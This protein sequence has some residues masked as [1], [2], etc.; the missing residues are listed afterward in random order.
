[1][2]SVRVICPA[3]LFALHAIAHASPD[4]DPTKGR[5]VFTGAATAN[6]T[7]IEINPAALGL[8]DVDE[9]YVAATGTLNHLSI[10]PRTLDIDSGSL[11]DGP[12][13]SDSLASPGGMAAYVWHN[14]KDG[15]I[16]LGVALHSAPAERFIAGE[17]ALRYFTLGGS[18]R[19]IGGSIASSIRVSSRFYFGLSLSLHTS[20]FELK[21]AR[22]TA[23]E[24]ARDPARGIDSDCGNGTPCGVGNPAAAER[25]DVSARTSW[26]ALENLVATLGFIVKITPDITL[27]VGYHN[28]P[29]LALQNELT[30]TMSVER[31]PRDG[32]G[33]VDGGATVYLQQPAS[34]DA[35][36]KTHLPYDLDLHVG[37]R[38]SDLSRMQDYDVRGYGSF[39][40]GA[41]IP[42]WQPRARG[43]HDPF[44]FW[45]G[46]E[47][48]GHEAPLALGGRIG[49]ETSA[50]AND[51]TSPLSVAPL[52]FTADVGASYV[53]VPGKL[54]LQATYGVQY[55]PSVDVKDSAFDPRD[56]LACYDS[57]YDYSTTAC[58]GVR[59]GY[60]LSSAAGDYGRIEQAARIALH[61]EL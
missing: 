5:A 6:P 2:S 43:F 10:T 36:V 53:L 23:L 52:S 45:A 55:F 32:G 38:W 51:K 8:R 42:E 19:T 46:V 35:E 54:V 60:A 1:M 58:K 18:F 49:F 7:A 22:D 28:P 39:F 14:G 24:A 47:Q 48:G 21:F 31:A 40:P 37:G 17:D 59:L 50:L 56:R 57:G 33:F 34:I 26:V 3:L 25:Y 27:G 20:F 15:R 61:Y 44:A 9:I 16:T 41:G 30:G 13:I 29:G 11:T 12:A 4:S